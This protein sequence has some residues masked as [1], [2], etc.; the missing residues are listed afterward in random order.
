MHS[1]HRLAK[2]K[3][4]KIFITTKTK[5]TKK[6]VMKVSKERRYNMKIIELNRRMKSLMRFRG[7]LK[8]ARVIVYQ[9]SCVEAGD[10]V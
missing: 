8:M 9:L 6:Y 5:P 4:K 2:N 3:V 10:T 7:L 1:G